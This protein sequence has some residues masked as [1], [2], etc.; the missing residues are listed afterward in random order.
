[1]SWKIQT[2]SRARIEVTGSLRP[3]QQGYFP[4]AHLML[5]VVLLLP[6]LC[7]LVCSAG[8]TVCVLCQVRRCRGSPRAVPV[9]VLS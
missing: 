5:P 2:A 4:H 3:F 8:M 9:C 7:W 1:M 6:H